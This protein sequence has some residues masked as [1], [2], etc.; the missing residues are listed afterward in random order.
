MSTKELVKKLVPVSVLSRLFFGGSYYTK[1]WFGK[2]LLGGYIEGLSWDGNVNALVLDRDVW[3]EKEIL[4]D[5]ES[6]VIVRLSNKSTMEEGLLYKNG[7]MVEKEGWRWLDD[8]CVILENDVNSAGDVWEMSYERKVEIESPVLSVTFGR[9][10]ASGFV[11]CRGRQIEKEVIIKEEL[12]FDSENRAKLFGLCSSRKGELFTDTGE[13]VTDWS[14]VSDNEIELNEVNRKRRYF[15]RY[16]GLVEVD[17]YEGIEVF[18][19]KNNGVWEKVR[20]GSQVGDGEGNYQLKVR[21]RKPLRKQDDV[22]IRYLGFLI[23]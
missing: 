22:R 13:V 14:F 8:S 4:K 10:F 5:W 9:V 1:G 20:L 3:V 19:R 17:D 15:F 16:N 2:E 11:Y 21:L 18:C 7:V 6:S 23:V 12:F